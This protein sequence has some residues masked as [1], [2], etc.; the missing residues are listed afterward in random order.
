MKLG[1]QFDSIY[2][3]YIWGK[4]TLNPKFLKIGNTSGKPRIIAAKWCRGSWGLWKPVVQRNPSVLPL[5]LTGAEEQESRAGGAQSKANWWLHL[6][7]SH[8]WFP[9]IWCIL[10]Y[11]ETSVGNMWRA[12]ACKYLKMKSNALF[13]NLLQFWFNF[14][15]VCKCL[16]FDRNSKLFW[17]R[18]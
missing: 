1:W 13:C 7:I 15:Q 2:Y 6:M 3:L 8:H 18:C 16:N 5:P 17:L 14:D 12:R 11:R 4:K 9:L 10:I